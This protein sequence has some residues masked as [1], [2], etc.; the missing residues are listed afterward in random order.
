MLPDLT[1]TVTSGDWGDCKMDRASAAC[2]L[3]RSCDGGGG[4]RWVCA[5]VACGAGVLGVVAAGAG[6]AM[7]GSG[8]EAEGSGA[9]N[10]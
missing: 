4:D 2:G 1:A 6:I 7:L 3:P 9:G 5:V 10:P 8:S